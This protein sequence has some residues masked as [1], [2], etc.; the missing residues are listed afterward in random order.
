M[1]EFFSKRDTRG[2]VRARAI[3]RASRAGVSLRVLSERWE[4]TPERIRQIKINEQR[5]FDQAKERK[6]GLLNGVIRVL[7]RAGPCPCGYYRCREI[8]T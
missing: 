7:P 3:W 8:R 4:V 1:K 5:R 2:K 6:Y